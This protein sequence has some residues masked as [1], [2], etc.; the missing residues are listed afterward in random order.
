MREWSRLSL[1]FVLCAS[2]S[3]AYAVPVQPTEL[4]LPST[5]PRGEVD[6][7]SG[8]NLY[9][10]AFGTSV[11]Q[12]LFYWNAAAPL[13]YRQLALPDGF[14]SVSGRRI[15]G[16]R[17]VGYAYDNHFVQHPLLWDANDPL[18]AVSLGFGD[19]FLYAYVESMDAARIVGFHSPN[20]DATGELP[21]YWNVADPA[22]AIDLP[23]PV[24]HIDI[25]AD[26][27]GVEQFLDVPWPE[28][29]AWLV[30][31]PKIAGYGYDVYDQQHVLYWDVS[32][33]APAVHTLK[34]PDFS[35]GTVSGIAGDIIAG[36]GYDNGP[37]DGVTPATG[38][39]PFYWDVSD[40]AAQDF[41]PI[42]LLDPASIY[43]GGAVTAVS[44]TN[45]VGWGH[46]DYYGPK[47]PLW[48][49]LSS[50]AAV[51]HELGTGGYF[52]IRIAGVSGDTIAGV[53]YEDAG[54]S[55]SHAI[56]WKTS[57][58][59]TVIQLGQGPWSDS[60]VVDVYG[61]DGNLI[62]GDI[63]D[64]GF[65]MHP[66]FWDL[67]ASAVP[68]NVSPALT[69]AGDQSA[70]EGAAAT[71]AL[72]SF[73]D[74]T[75][76]PWTVSIDWGD[77]SGVETF[78]VAAD[79]AL[80]S[81]AHTF[82]DSG[83]YSVTVT[84]TDSGGLSDT[85][86]FTVAAANVAPT[87]TLSN[88]GPIDE[89]GSVTVSFGGAFDPSPADMAAGFRYAFSCTGGSLD[90]A[91]G[92]LSPSTSCSFDDNGA[93]VVTARIIDQDGGYTDYSTTVTVNDVAPTAAFSGGSGVAGTPISYAFTSAFE[94]SQADTAAGFG[95]AISCGA[96]FAGTPSFTTVS[97]GTCT[98]ASPGTYTVYGRI[99]DKDGAF[100][101]YTASTSVSAA[102][103][104][105]GGGKLGIAS[106]GF[107]L[108][109][110]RSL[111]NRLEINWPGGNRFSLEGLTAV[112]C[113]TD[114][115]LAAAPPSASFNTMSGAGTGRLNG[116][117][118]ATVSFVFAD[119]GEQGTR[120]AGAIVVRDARGAT[121]LSVPRSPVS[122]GNIQAHDP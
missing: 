114:P 64:A 43:L 50:G 119:G 87:A 74:A 104:M 22:T 100:S 5:H 120:D 17:I 94:P 73:S 41:E 95:Y 102:G 47:L 12:S 112:S 69:V 111:P 19:G 68:V 93:Y 78:S 77:G 113:T 85:K 54:C 51:L 15:V 88:S 20:A 83:S 44:G 23:L 1:P 82:A 121:V 71:I 70:S 13:A 6:G 57:D 52:C 97:T 36:Y 79:G 72:G 109:C 42:P 75:S 26:D 29:Q 99:I 101:E 7:V 76:G 63:F 24:Q 46:T 21:A 8:L 117:S 118:G 110:D 56:Y 80:G 58:P 98:F 2:V 105:T 59:A 9:G 115:G 90:G 60:P 65:F 66:V 10:P 62:V 32:G 37:G 107:E 40:P 30:E 116:A 3:A 45:L 48:W 81:L 11:G 16:T 31:G 103:R 27:S 18:T 96:P 53:G 122:G 91:S 92:D 28:G 61:I 4:A 67:G 33:D 89:G 38:E 14:M 25:G 86:A 35:V 49:D 106:D 55:I 34:L 108:H 84:V 39:H